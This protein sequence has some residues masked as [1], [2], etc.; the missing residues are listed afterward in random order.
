MPGSRSRCTSPGARR[1]SI[2]TGAVAAVSGISPSAVAQV[3]DSRP[4]LRASLGVRAWVG[5]RVVDLAHDEG[6]ARRRAR[7][8]AVRDELGRLP[9]DGG[10]STVNPRGGPLTSLPATVMCAVWRLA[11]G[12][13]DAET[14]AE[15]ATCDGVSAADGATADG[16]DCRRRSDRRRDRRRWRPR[17][18]RR[19]PSRRRP[20]LS[21]LFTGR[22]L[23]A[24][25]LGRRH[26]GRG[27]LAI[28]DPFRRAPAYP[29]LHARMSPVHLRV[30]PSSGWGPAASGPGVEMERLG[31][32]PLMMGGAAAEPPRSVSDAARP[33][34][35]RKERR[36]RRLHGARHGRVRPAAPHGE[37]HPAQRRSRR[38][39]GPGVAHRRLAA[40]PRRPRPGSLRRMAP[41]P[42]RP[43]LLSG[44][45][46][47][48]RRDVVEIHMT[49][50]DARGHGDARTDRH[51]R[52]ARAGLPSADPRAARRTGRPPLPGAVGCRGG[53]GPRY[54]VGTFKSRLHRPPPLFVRRSKPTNDPTVATESIA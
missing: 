30:V 4:D 18:R 26:R 46:A 9:I 38:R 22:A 29:A 33:C 54:P 6:H 52:P 39:C 27:A 49:M 53:D 45:A 51:P 1:P 43:R 12:T 15:G 21:V 19:S 3:R 41:S 5:E 35:S 44:G 20:T 32:P 11:L 25:H 31:F 28:D 14:T 13:G 48:Q 37:A 34:P 50:P 8:A 17:R 10:S 16:G 2:W 40:H 24:D 7:R 23:L 42:A 47:D 36:P